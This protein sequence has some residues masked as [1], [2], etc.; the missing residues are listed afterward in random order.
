[1]RYPLKRSPTGLVPVAL[2]IL[3]IVFGASASKLSAKAN[4]SACCPGQQEANAKAQAA[5]IEGQ[6]QAAQLNAQA[7]QVIQHGNQTAAEYDAKANELLSSNTGVACSPCGE[8]V[9]T[10]PSCEIQ[11]Q[12]ADLRGEGA[13]ARQQA[14]DEASKLR[15]QAC[16]AIQDSKDK[17]LQFSHEAICALEQCRAA[18]SCNTCA[19]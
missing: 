1:M 12:A 3:L 18:T 2:A 10:P 19:P 8:K 17:A 4:G 14:M 6:N 9:I 11:Q 15:A 13:K 7:N 16:Q 5:L